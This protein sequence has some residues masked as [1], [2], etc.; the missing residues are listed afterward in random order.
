MNTWKWIVQLI[1]IIGGLTVLLALVIPQEEQGIRQK[2]VTHHKML[3]YYN[4]RLLE[5]NDILDEELFLLETHSDSL[6]TLIAKQELKIKELKT[7]IKY[8]NRLSK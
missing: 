1:I 7:K 6:R 3:A 5:V 8:G 4:K 2:E